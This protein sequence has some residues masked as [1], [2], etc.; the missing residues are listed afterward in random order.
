MDLLKCECRKEM[1]VSCKTAI[2]KK[3]HF[4]RT[5]VTADLPIGENK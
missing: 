2:H 1:S 4:L 3:P 5:S